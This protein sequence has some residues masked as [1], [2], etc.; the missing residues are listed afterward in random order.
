MNKF[1]FIPLISLLFI[2]F[3]GNTVVTINQD[4]K[5]KKTIFDINPENLS[6]LNTK[7]LESRIG[8]KL[9]FKEKIA[10]K[11]IKVKSRNKNQEIK[12]ELFSTAGF[13]IGVI[14]WLLIILSGYQGLQLAAIFGILAFCLSIVGLIRIKRNPESKKGKAFAISGLFLGAALVIFVTFLAFGRLF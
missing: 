14:G 10:F 2:P 9:K 8:R 7:K 6:Q 12:I 4:F 13:S 5:S 1:I 3:Y 11:L